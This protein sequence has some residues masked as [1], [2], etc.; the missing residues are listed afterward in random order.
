VDRLFALL[1]HVIDQTV[2]EDAESVA[3][4]LTFSARSRSREPLTVI[5]DQAG[6]KKS[7]ELRP[8]RIFPQPSDRSH[9]EKA[10]GGPPCWALRFHGLSVAP[11]GS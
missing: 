7:A 11:V 10:T 4:R 9:S 2:G 5:S 6:P 1:A 3:Y 8:I